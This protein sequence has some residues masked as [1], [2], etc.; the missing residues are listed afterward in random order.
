[1]KVVVNIK[2]EN[3]L[4]FGIVK[5]IDEISYVENFT[6]SNLKGNFTAI[7]VFAFLQDL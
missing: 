6:E 3:F 4:D 7:F 1:M 5:V 2:D